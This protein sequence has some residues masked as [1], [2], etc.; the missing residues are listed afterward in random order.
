MIASCTQILSIENSEKS[1]N[2][3]AKYTCDFYFDI[4]FTEEKK[5]QINLI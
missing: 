3:I 4:F 5:T 2:I 1:L